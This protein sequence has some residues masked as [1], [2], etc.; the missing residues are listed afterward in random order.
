MIDLYCERTGP[1]LWAEPFNA[2]TNLSFFVAAWFAWRL[3]AGPDRR[4]S[5]TSLVILI[6]AIG[7]G[8]EPHFWRWSSM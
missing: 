3:I 6:V 4:S 8:G 1:G 7:R 5:Q 2:L